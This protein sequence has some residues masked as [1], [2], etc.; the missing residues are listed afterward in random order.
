MR[1]ANGL[2]AAP[3]LIR[4]GDTERVLGGNGH[5]DQ[6]ERVEAEILSK[7]FV[8]SHH[9]PVHLRDLPS[10]RVTVA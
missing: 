5:L 4:K 3:I 8:P 1:S 6:R 9:G 7:A 2:E 10:I